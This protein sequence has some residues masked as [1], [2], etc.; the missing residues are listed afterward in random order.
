MTFTLA[1]LLADFPLQTSKMAENKGI[2]W[3]KWGTINY[4][5]NKAK[6]IYLFFHILV[7]LVTTLII[8]LMIKELN[9][10][11]L[12]PSITKLMII[13]GVIIFIHGT[14]DFFKYKLMKGL[15]YLC[16]KCG[17]SD[18]LNK[19]LVFLLDQLL[20]IGV[21]YLTIVLFLKKNTLSFLNS[22]L[23]INYEL[24][25]LDKTLLVL[26]IGLIGTYF[27][28]YFINL[29][30]EPNLLPK[31][32][33]DDSKKISIEFPLTKK[34]FEVGFK[35]NF[36]TIT[37][38]KFNNEFEPE[39]NSEIKTESKTESKS[40]NEH[41]TKSETETK[42]ETKTEKKKERRLEQT[43]IIQNRDNST[44]SFGMPIGLI[45]RILI[46][47]LVSTGNYATIAIIIALKTL[48]RFKM[49]EQNKDFGEYYL[50]GNLLSLAFS[51]PAGILIK[52]IL[53]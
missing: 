27:A 11:Y 50:M 3:A 44:I 7:H 17:W 34:Q 36:E 37:E 2:E 39:Y 22:D 35:D 48:T 31:Y 49:I 23:Y 20:H 43:I 19:L 24:N 12:E 15:K 5:T 30:L 4:R 45:E 32:T 38:K 26:I 18:K 47:L 10:D 29:Y 13:T 28:A 1:H 53:S 40:E 52:L 16:K 9:K 6:S 21:I 33:Y 8:I 46:I 41:G 25:Y 51:I 42:T 14:I